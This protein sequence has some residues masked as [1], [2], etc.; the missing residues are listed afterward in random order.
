MTPIGINVLVAM[1]SLLFGCLA[2]TAAASLLLGVLAPAGIAN[3]GQSGDD[4][5]T[6]SMPCSSGSVCNMT[7]ECSGTCPASNV[8]ALAAPNP[9]N[10]LRSPLASPI[11]SLAT[12]APELHKPP[13]KPA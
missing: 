10:L 12:V 3:S 6:M 11:L 7:A 5:S 13:P 2:V 4:G 8:A 9:G 1:R